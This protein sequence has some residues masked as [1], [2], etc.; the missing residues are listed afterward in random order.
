MAN[1]PAST[2]TT[3][4]SASPSGSNGRSGRTWREL[5]PPTAVWTSHRS[6][7]PSWAQPSM[8]PPEVGRALVWP[9]GRGGASSGD[10]S[11]LNISE[12][13][14]DAVVCSLSD[15]LEASVHPRFFLSPRAAAGILRRAEAR[16]RAL[17]EHLRV[18]LL[19][20]SAA[21][22]GPEATTPE[23][24]SERSQP[25]GPAETSART[26]LPPHSLPGMDDPA[27]TPPVDAKR[28][29]STSSP[30]PSERSGST[31]AKTG[32]G[33][34]PRSPSSAP[35]RPASREAMECP[36]RQQPTDD[37]SSSPMGVFQQSSM[38]GKGTIGYIP[39][40]T[41]SQPVGQML[42]L[43]E[44]LGKGSTV[45]RL[46]PT[47]CERLMGWPDGWCV[48]P[49]NPMTVEDAPVPQ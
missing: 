6:W 31:P 27:P 26:S 45:R 11:T 23:G 39:D 38:K 9:L 12:C 25:E 37:F 42:H 30:T 8:F 44:P 32:P 18:A 33:E 40:P 48:W 29:T 24:S 4:G 2:G 34:E 14:N 7:L 1:A 20:L 49:G 36:P 5:S 10:Y 19:A 22:A 17:P 21:T 47:E 46:T 3:S 16:G 28:T 15:V 41:V 43:Q 13:P 35:S